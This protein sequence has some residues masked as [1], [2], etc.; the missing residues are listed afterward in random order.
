MSRGLR[1]YVNAAASAIG[2]IVDLVS[3]RWHSHR[4]FYWKKWASFFFAAEGGK[5]FFWG[6]IRGPR[7]GLHGGLESGYKGATKRIQQ[8]APT[9]QFNKTRSSRK[10]KGVVGGLGAIRLCNIV[11]S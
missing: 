5:S 11:R 8:G 2:R 1:V 3:D 10:Y 7:E 9:A 6:L 4:F